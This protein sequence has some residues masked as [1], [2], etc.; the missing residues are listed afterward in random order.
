MKIR[1]LNAQNWELPPLPEP[2]NFKPKYNLP[3]LD[4]YSKDRFPASYWS[5]WTKRTLDMVLPGSS[6]VSSDCLRELADRANFPHTKM[7]ER[8]CNRLD[9]GANVGCEGRGRLPTVANN[10]KHVYEFGDR[11][12]DAL[13]DWI[14]E[15]IAAGPLKEEELKRLGQHYTVNPLG[16]KLK[17]NGKIRVLV[18]ASGPHDEDE[19][20]PGWIWNTEMPGSVNSTI[21]SS[22]FPTK[23]SSVPKFVRA[24][25]RCGRG[26]IVDKLDYTSAYKHQHVEEED[27]CLQVIKWGDRYFVELKLIFGS[28]S[29]PGI[30]D[31]LAKVFLWCCMTLSDMPRNLVEQHLDDVLGIGLQSIDSP[32]WKFHQTFVDEAKILGIRLDSSGNDDKQQEPKTT[33]VALGVQ[34][35]TKSW[36][37]GFKEDK[38]SRIL[39]TLDSIRNC[40]TIPHKEMESITGKLND[41]RFLVQGGKY[42]MLY[43]LRAVHR[44]EEVDGNKIAVTPLLQEQAKWWMTALMA[45]NMESAILHP[46]T[47]FPSNAKEAWTDAAGGTS[48]HMG[49]G[50]GVVVPTGEWAYLPW[51]AW[52]NNGGKNSD[53]VRFAN[54]MSCLEMLGPL[55]ALCT[56]GKEVMSEVLIVHVDN[57]GSVDIYR[58]GHTTGCV[59]TST[60]AKACFDLAMSMGCTLVVKKIRRCS[61][62]GSLLADMISKGD[63]AE[64]R[65][66]MPNRYLPTMLPTTLVNW[67]KDPVEDLHLGYRI[68]EELKEQLEEIIPVD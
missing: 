9:K 49:A 34:F 37:W 36:T 7:L 59:Y 13:Q 51:P 43:F 64:F 20:V 22:Q 12:S 66:L 55:A 16:A 62:A 23:M 50:M 38:L 65:K 24:L 2:V 40:Q 4:D 27:L 26:A 58:K 46:D 19:S 18:D 39:H 25:W 52:L 54:K 60:V 53:G 68:A 45:A 42:N 56:M 67:V 47:Q 30:F 14:C 15:G 33:V 6:W 21:D 8:V 61:D 48:S 3:H 17:P 1:R 35:N 57:Q 28:R 29:S 41:V 31:E 11:I 32:V 44:S 5:K 63:L 10:S